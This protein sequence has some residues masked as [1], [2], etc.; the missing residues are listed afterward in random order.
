MLGWYIR[1][2]VDSNGCQGTA[3]HAQKFM[4]HDVLFAQESTNI[5]EQRLID[6]EG[7]EFNLTDHG[8][9]LTED[10]EPTLE[11]IQLC[12]LDVDFYEEIGRAHV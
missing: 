2:V 10:I 8:D 1:V 7:Y 3:C 6:V 5:S 9:D 12:A 4:E 11:D